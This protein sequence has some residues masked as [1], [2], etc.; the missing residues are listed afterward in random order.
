MLLKAF[1]VFAYV[2]SEDKVVGFHEILSVLPFLAD[3][4]SL[5]ECLPF[6]LAF[7]VFVIDC[8]FYS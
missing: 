6:V 3:T 4:F 2:V 8:S 1:L 7:T 5:L